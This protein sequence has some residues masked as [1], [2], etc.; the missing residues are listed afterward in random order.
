[1]PRQFFVGGNFKMNGVTST[2][3]SIVSNLNNSKRDPNTEVVVAPPALYLALVRELADPSVGVAAQNVYDKPNGAFTGELS[4]E[5]LKD[6]KIDWAIVGH[7]ERRVLLREDDDFVARKTK[8]AIDGGLSVILCIGESLEERE[9]TKTIEVV[10]RQLNAVAKLV[11]EEQ[12]SKIVIAYEPIWAIG[13]GKVATTT[14]AQEVHAAIRKWL[15]ET[16]SAKVAD[17]TRILYGGSVS[18]GN[19]KDLAKEKDIDGFLVGGASLKP[20]FVDIINARL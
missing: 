10:T 1:M 12:W 3:K 16:I 15:G 20:A 4:V 7:S 5:Q 17:E 18:D 6:A 19:C 8:A 11:S 9:A 13:T 14:Q 2:I